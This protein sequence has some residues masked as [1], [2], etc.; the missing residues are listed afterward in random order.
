MSN[1]LPLLPSG[2]QTFEE[3]RQKNAIYVDKTGFISDLILRGKV[4]FCSRPRRF[5]KSLTV[6]MLD[7]FFSGKKDLFKG[8]KAEEIINSPKFTPNPVI[9]L[10]M[11]AVAGS[12]SKEELDTRI[13][14][15]LLANAKR[16]KVLLHGYNSIDSFLNLIEDIYEASS[17]KVVILIDE[18]DSPA[19]QVMGN[20]DLLI[21]TREIM[22][23]FYSQIKVADQYI[24]FTFITGISKF[25]KMGVFS[26]LNNISDIS[27]EYKFGSFFGITQDE[28]NKNFIY[29]INDATKKLKI[30]N[31]VLIEKIR[32]KYDGF[33]FD[34]MTFLYNPFSTVEFFQTFIFDNFWIKSASNTFIIDYISKHRLTPDELENIVID[35]NFASSP[36]DIEKGN[37]I[38]FLYQAGYLSLRKIDDNRFNLSYPNEEVRKSM[39]EIFIRCGYKDDKEFISA[40]DDLIGYLINKDIPKIINA[41]NIMYSKID[42]VDY[43]IEERNGR[44]ESTYRALLLCFF[45]CCGVDVFSEVHGNLGRADLIARL[46]GRTYVIE[47]K[48]AK[49]AATLKKAAKEG[50]EQIY[51][52]NYAGAYPGAVTICLAINSVKRRIGF[53]LYELDGKTHA[54]DLQ[55]SA[56][57]SGSNT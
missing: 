36:G 21:M 54:L 43:A 27:M 4:I 2:I 18:Y 44:S 34:G 49:S 10:D 12:K 33:C 38:S 30:S 45:S 42:Y 47:L 40:K 25:S 35:Y 16:N 53:C 31:K 6:S 56:R 19:L 5:G 7:D 52:K 48:Y 41:I 8:L 28:L 32:S 23:N 24:D 39:Q 13:N 50:M 46:K 9:R 22:S 26:T 1:D 17:Q 11:S 15:R 29:Y 37:P 51:A 14:S 3:I 57:S 20:T 55:K